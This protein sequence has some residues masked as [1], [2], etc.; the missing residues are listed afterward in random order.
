MTAVTGRSL[1]PCVA[2]HR[3]PWMSSRRAVWRGPMMLPTNGD[4]YDQRDETSRR[5]FLFWRPAALSQSV[6]TTDD[7]RASGQWTGRG[8]E[9]DEDLQSRMRTL[10]RRRGNSAIRERAD[11]RGSTRDD[12]G[13]RADELPGAAD[14][15]RRTARPPR[16]L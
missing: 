16:H 14:L 8:L 12:R 11:H 7:R 10:L 9:C 6:R 3:E 5:F 13:S 4:S 15:R 2:H 1:P